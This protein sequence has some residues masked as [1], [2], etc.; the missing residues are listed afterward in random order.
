MNVDK[1]MKRIDLLKSGK[2]LIMNHAAYGTYEF[3]MNPQQNN[4][5]A[6]AIDSLGGNFR[7]TLLRIME[8]HLR[9]R[10]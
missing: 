2:T 3:K 8:S 4:I 6:K 7:K 9:S 10:I 5:F 1:L